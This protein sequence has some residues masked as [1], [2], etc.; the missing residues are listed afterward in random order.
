MNFFQNS[1]GV[2]PM[3]WVMQQKGLRMH[4]GFRSTRLA[5]CSGPIGQCPAIKNYIVTNRSV[6]SQGSCV[7]AS[8]VMATKRHHL[9]T[10]RTLSPLGTRVSC[11]PVLKLTSKILLEVLTMAVW[12]W[13]CHLTSLDLSSLMGKWGQRSRCSLNYLPNPK[14]YDSAMDMEAQ[15]IY[16]SQTH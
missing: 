8:W 5:A 16:I 10:C 15:A 13:A 1:T 14:V 11:G 7:S 4:Y 3:L 2:A 6:G 12:L 9:P